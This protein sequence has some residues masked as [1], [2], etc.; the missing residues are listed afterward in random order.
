MST[1]ASISRVVN[2]IL[3]AAFRAAI[4]F[5]PKRMPRPVETGIR[6]TADDSG[7]RVSAGVSEGVDHIDGLFS[8][9]FVASLPSNP[10]GASADIVLPR[11][12]AESWGKAGVESIDIEDNYAAAAGARVPVDPA[13]DFPRFP[14]VDNPSAVYTLDFPTFSAIANHVGSATDDESSRYALGGILVESGGDC[15]RFVGTDGR[16]LHAARVAGASDGAFN[17]IIPAAVWSLTTKAIDRTIDEKG[18]TKRQALQALRVTLRFDDSTGRGVFAWSVSTLRFQV[19][20]RKVDGRFPRWR[21]CFPE[22]LAET[23]DSRYSAE[24]L[25][26]TNVGHID[27]ADIIGHAE[28]C[29]KTICSANSKGVEIERS[30][31]SVTVSARSAERG[32]YRQP[33]K[34]L[35]PMGFRRRLDPAFLVDALR[36]CAAFGDDAAAVHCKPGEIGDSPEG[37]ASAVFFGRADKIFA[38]DVCQSAIFAAVIMPLGD[39]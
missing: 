22:C 23:V 35:L 14:S 4:L 15:V 13:A 32:E 7:I 8:V 29:R 34:G 21:D 9:G 30:E 24:K 6:L 26:A 18:K 17:I 5:A 28:T 31:N 3:P 33:V 10:E 16:R 39:D 25:S 38:G 1:V 37:R 19:S 11:P 27:I 2:T 20:F 36:G 12:A